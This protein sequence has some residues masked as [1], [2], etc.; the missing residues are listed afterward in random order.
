MRADPVIATLCCASSSEK[1][2]SFIGPKKKRKGKRKK[3]TA[4]NAREVFRCNFQ[5]FG[6]HLVL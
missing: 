3:E 1:S 5:I 6:A 4:A 2:V